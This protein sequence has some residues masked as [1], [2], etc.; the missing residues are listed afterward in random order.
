MSDDPLA[1]LY[2]ETGTG[3]VD[4]DVEIPTRETS[5]EELTD[6]TGGPEE[7][8]DEDVEELALLIRSKLVAARESIAGVTDAEAA[9]LGLGTLDD[10]EL[11]LNDVGRRVIRKILELDTGLDFT[12]GKT[13]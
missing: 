11:V 8:S 1:H 5:L 13:Q 9:A 4:R 3:P 7:I 6:E 10:D 2:A 12:E